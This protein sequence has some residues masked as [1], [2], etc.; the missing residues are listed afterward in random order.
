MGTDIRYMQTVILEKLHER[1]SFSPNTTFEEAAQ[2]FP[3]DVDEIFDE[4]HPY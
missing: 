4:I 2:K 1:H 3:N